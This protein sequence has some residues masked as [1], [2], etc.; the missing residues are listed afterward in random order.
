MTRCQRCKAID[1]LIF[2]CSQSDRLPT[3]REAILRIKPSAAMRVQS[4]SLCSPRRLRQQWTRTTSSLR[5]IPATLYQL[6]RLR[7]NSGVDYLLIEPEPLPDHGVVVPDALGRAFFRH[8][9][10]R[11][12][13][14]HLPREV[15]MMFQQLEP[16]ASG[17]PGFGLARLKKQL[18]KEYGVD[19]DHLPEPVSPAAL[20]VRLAEG[21]GHVAQSVD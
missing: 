15:L 11:A 5:L 4:S 2:Y 12:V 10:H 16:T 20:I 18:L 9:V 8:C 14:D 7:E 17:V 19:V 6:K 3:G 1:R 21:G 13:C